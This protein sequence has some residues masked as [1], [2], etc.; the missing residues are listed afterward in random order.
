MA[1]RFRLLFL[2]LLLAGAGSAALAADATPQAIEPALERRQITAAAIDT[3][4][5]EF[6]IFGGI[7]SIED[8]GAQPV[9][10]LRLA[11]H[12]SE[13]LFLEAA[14]GRSKAGETSYESLSGNVQLLTDDERTFSYYNLSVGYNLLPGEVF[15]GSRWA[16]N[17]AVYVIGGIGSTSFADD[18]HFTFNAGFGY[19]LLAT[20]WLALHLDVR[21]HIFNSDLLGK[22]KTT[23]NLELHGGI[24]VFF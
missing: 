18:K 12:V 11:Y 2:G 13:D 16:F 7:I 15:F 3:E 1:G 5:L 9:Y 4:N 23:H 6:G 8:F 10:G 22:D 24:T 17:T 14:Y 21:D 20:D 19:R